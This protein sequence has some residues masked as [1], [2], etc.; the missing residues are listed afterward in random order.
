MIAFEVEFLRIIARTKKSFRIEIIIRITRKKVPRNFWENRARKVI[1]RESEWV[2][3]FQNFINSDQF[4]SNPN[5]KK[6]MQELD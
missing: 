6:I 2:I 1:F 3:K 4:I 5:N